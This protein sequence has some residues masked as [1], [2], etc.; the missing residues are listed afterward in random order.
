MAREIVYS[1][2]VIDGVDECEAY[3]L[4]EVRE[5]ELAEHDVLAPGAGVGRLGAVEEGAEA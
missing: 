5:A 2:R 3:V 1:R 4:A